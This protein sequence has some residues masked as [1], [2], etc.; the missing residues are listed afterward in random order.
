MV[1]TKR[2]VAVIGK[3]VEKLEPSFV[4]GG[5]VTWFSHFGKQFD[6]FPKC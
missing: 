6:T 5:I 3:D 4:V 1:K 2:T